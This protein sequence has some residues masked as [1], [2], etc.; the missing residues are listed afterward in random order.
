M[1]ICKANCSR[2]C[3]YAHA[4]VCTHVCVCVCVAIQSAILFHIVGIKLHSHRYLGIKRSPLVGDSLPHNETINSRI[5]LSPDILYMYTLYIYWTTI[6]EYILFPMYTQTDKDIAY[7]F[8]HI[9]THI[10]TCIPTIFFVRNSYF[11]ID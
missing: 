5:E 7:R 8:I 11:V 6:H 1:N 2:I 4:H 3:I 10:Y 9:Y